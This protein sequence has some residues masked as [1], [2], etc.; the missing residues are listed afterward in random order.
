VKEKAQER[1]RGQVTSRE[2]NESEPLPCRKESD[3]V[4]T[5][6]VRRSWDKA[7]AGTCL[8]TERHPA[9]RWPEPRRG[10]RMEHE[11]LGVDANGEAT[12]GLNHE[13]ESTNVMLRDGLPGSSEEAE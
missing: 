12:S 10:G 13:G 11:N 6:V 7:P 1:N 3:G 5:T 4:E 2:R 9:Y 8:R